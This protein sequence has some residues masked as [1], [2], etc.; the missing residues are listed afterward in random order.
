[1]C[2]ARYRLW[3]KVPS[4]RKV[5]EAPAGGSG[6][7]G[8]GKRAGFKKGD[9]PVSPGTGMAQCWLKVD[10]PGMQISFT[11]NTGQLKAYPD[12]AGMARPA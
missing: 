1:M 3:K 11:D 8:T 6:R 2:F 7:W 4:S 12:A 5:R 9:A 10:I